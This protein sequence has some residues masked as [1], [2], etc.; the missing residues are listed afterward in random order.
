MIR[1]ENVIF[2]WKQNAFIR[3]W[4]ISL[5]LTNSS[6]ECGALWMKQHCLL[7]LS[8]FSSDAGRKKSFKTAVHEIR[9]S[10]WAGIQT[11]GRPLLVPA[12]GSWVPTCM[13]SSCFP[14]RPTFYLALSVL[15]LKWQV[16]V[17]SFGN[18]STVS[19][20]AGAIHLS[21]TLGHFDVGTNILIFTPGSC[22]ARRKG[23]W[24]RQTG[25]GSP[26]QEGIHLHFTHRV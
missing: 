13:G 14:Q 8:L 16:S 4:G 26:H 9:W 5:W 2:T 12:G 20:Q 6:K 7:F 24:Q 11:V 25:A 10:S 23:G 18:L 1:L 21:L 3:Y 19:Q 17:L 15:V 22:L